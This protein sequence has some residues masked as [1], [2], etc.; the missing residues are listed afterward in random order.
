[1]QV[2]HLGDNLICSRNTYS[3]TYMYYVQ[4]PLKN[5]EHTVPEYNQLMVMNIS[6]QFLF[7]CRDKC[8]NWL[9]RG[10]QDSTLSTSELEDLMDLDV[11]FV[12]V[13]IKGWSFY[14]SRSI[15]RNP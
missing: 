3:N 2:T 11:E 6:F 5:I 4:K 15:G 13:L 12:L 9:F 7:I 10:A 8:K 14:I 1:M